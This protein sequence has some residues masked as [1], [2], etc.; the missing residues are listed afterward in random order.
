MLKYNFTEDEVNSILG[1]MDE[2]L[3]YNK[4]LMEINEQMKK[5]MS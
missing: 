5:L 1:M 3:N 2:L 4:E